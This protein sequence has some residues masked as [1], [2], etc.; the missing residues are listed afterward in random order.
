MFD[1]T[2]KLRL[3]ACVAAVLCMGACSRNGGQA[4]TA[5]AP[6]APETPAGW[7]VTADFVA[8]VEQVKAMS[9]KLGAKLSGVRNTI[10]SVEG[11]RAQINVMVT[12]DTKNAE[13]LMKKLRS[14][15]AEEAFVQRGLTIYEFVGENDVLPEM[16]EVR[17]H[18]AEM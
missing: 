3:A 8:P 1:A 16:M 2:R 5:E 15:K 10:Y 17:K 11:K 7:E 12:P 18:L 13:K 4:P 14:M 6:A 9:K